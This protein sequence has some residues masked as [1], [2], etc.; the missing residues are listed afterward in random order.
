LI[1]LLRSP[2]DGADIFFRLEPGNHHF[3]A[4]SQAPE[5]EIRAGAE[6]QPP[7]FPA[8]VGLFHHKDIV[9]LNIHI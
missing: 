8:G 3:S 9:Q 7:L 1:L 4:A 5:P 6:N 2:L